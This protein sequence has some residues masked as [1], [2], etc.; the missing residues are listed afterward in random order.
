MTMWRPNLAGKSGPKYKLIAEAIGEG[1]ADGGL[2]A[3][4]RLP[5][6]RDLAYALGI[7]LNTVSRAYAEA[8]R[9]G[10]LD[11]EVGRGTYV[12]AGG[13]L[14]SQES[15][16]AMTRPTDGPIDFTLN[17][18]AA[19]NGAAALAE[20]LG[21]LKESAALAAYLDYQTEGDLVRH[22]RSAAT[23][24][25]RLGLA[26]SSDDVVLTNGAQH[27]LIVAMLAVMRPGDVL[28]TEAMTYAPVKA[29]AQHLGLRLFPVALDD[30]GLSPEALDAACRTTAA[31][32]LYCL[33]TLHTPTAVTMTAERRRD[34]AAIA[35][36][37]D[38]LI[39]EDDVFGFLPPDR[40][41]PLACHAPERS[42]FITSVS[43]SLAPGLRVGF[44][45]AP[46]RFHRS[47]RA[48]VNL[49]CWMPPPLM[50]EI[51]SRWI[52]EGT[53]Q[54]LNHF[55]RAEAQAR[56]RIARDLLGTFD[57]R[58]DPYGFHVWLPLP[59]QWRAD[60]FRV[61]AERQGVKVLTGETFAVAQGDAPQAIRLCLSHEATRARVT[62][63]LEIVAGLLDE[64]GDPGVLV[65]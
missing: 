17:L 13:P 14:P 42:L 59:A 43:K 28:L 58:A 65:V 8:I 19:G 25:G 16:A 60:A 63:G 5:P 40:P 41:T 33:P 6:Q 34:I 15:C 53:A 49:S 1:I 50:A 38:L 55:Q 30:G 26:V 57:L 35:R 64:T 11:G 9:R 46:R 61:A 39:I 4:D 12:R 44:L 52:D 54:R 48:V 3:R 23:W 18:P 62:R 56:Q 22:A 32:T 29:M 51:A 21:S 2:T 31:K 45:H 10:F 47:L 7:S 24:I 36:K 20:T 37:H 27:A